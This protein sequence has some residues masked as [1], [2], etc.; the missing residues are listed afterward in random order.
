MRKTAAL[1]R[2]AFAEGMAHNNTDNSVNGGG[3][4]ET[5]LVRRKDST[6]TTGS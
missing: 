6:P 2:F 4:D 3:S 5:Q 1:Q